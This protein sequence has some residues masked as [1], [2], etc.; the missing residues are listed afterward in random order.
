MD[1]TKWSVSIIGVFDGIV[2]TRTTFAY[3]YE[4]TRELFERY[5]NLARRNVKKKQRTRYNR[6][7]QEV[8]DF[9]GEYITFLDE[10]G[11]KLYTVMI[12]EKDW[13]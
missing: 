3:D 2:E 5:K 1:C 10:L 8:T 4:T 11:D 7:K 6:K 13:N 9:D 12:T